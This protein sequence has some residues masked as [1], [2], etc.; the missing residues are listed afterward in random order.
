MDVRALDAGDIPLAA[1]FDVQSVPA[2]PLRTRC[3]S[4]PPYPSRSVVFKFDSVA[5]QKKNRPTE[6]PSTACLSGKSTRLVASFNVV[7]S[8]HEKI[9]LPRAD[10]CC[11]STSEKMVCMGSD[12]EVLIDAS[13][14]EIPI[15]VDSGRTGRRVRRECYRHRLRQTLLS[16]FGTQRCH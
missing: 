16:R 12:F 2:H 3:P 15:E 4:L 10:G 1:N 14:P 5:V 11:S 6:C 8:K 9:R 13:R 7:P